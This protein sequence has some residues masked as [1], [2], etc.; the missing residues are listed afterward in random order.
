MRDSYMTPGSGRERDPF[1]GRWL[2]TASRRCL[3]VRLTRETVA[4]AVE[5]VNVAADHAGDAVEVCR[6][7][8][9]PASAV[10]VARDGHTCVRIV[11]IATARWLRRRRGWGGGMARSVSLG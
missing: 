9:A 6:A 8:P 4:V 10:D 5:L 2:G 11:G 1:F 7:V 3:S